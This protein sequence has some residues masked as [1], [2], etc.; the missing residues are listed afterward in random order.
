MIK[1]EMRRAQETVLALRSMKVRQAAR[2]IGVYITDRAQERERT[3]VRAF[4]LWQRGAAKKR[5][6]ETT[7]A[8]TAA[9]AAVAE[10]EAAHAQAMAAM[11][12]ERSEA[13]A[14]AVT[15]AAVSAFASAEAYQE[16]RQS[17][18]NAD[19]EQGQVAM[20][21]E[22]Q[23]LHTQVQVLVTGLRASEL[24]Q[25][26]MSLVMLA[27]QAHYKWRRYWLSHGWRLLQTAAC[28]M[29]Q[30][31]RMER[32]TVAVL[33]RKAWAAW[34]R[35]VRE[36]WR[37]GAAR[38]AA[39]SVSVGRVRMAASLLSAAALR[40][41]QRATVELATAAAVAAS[42]LVASQRQLKLQIQLDAANAHE[43]RSEQLHLE[44]EH[45][46][47]QKFK[48]AQCVQSL[49]R[50]LNVLRWIQRVTLARRLR[51]WR[52]QASSASKYESMANRMAAM[53]RRMERQSLLRGFNIWR[54]VQITSVQFEKMKVS[55]MKSS[56][57]RV[58]E[59]ISRMQQHMQARALNSWR[60]RCYLM[61]KFETC[62]LSI[63][64]ISSILYCHWALSA[65]H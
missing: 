63:H 61:E 27:A 45:V 51:I 53:L 8:A 58:R 33:K 31:E 39:T 18:L 37:A 59:V 49:Q 3:R 55:Q 40:R 5:A 17:A 24:Q 48:V 52:A 2:L 4:A 36:H 6:M 47:E 62:M 30:L 15:A 54:V 22:S 19:A 23:Q 7:A 13:E 44:K 28:Q 42:A 43:Q 26:G 57:K 38:A 25:S 35:V 1:Q 65:C 10:M 50:L 21:A 34:A 46:V 11:L 64:A 9:A 20:R 29:H 16:Q 14:E 12:E 32:L 41:W 56:V 60:I